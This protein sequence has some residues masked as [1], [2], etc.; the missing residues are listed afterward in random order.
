MQGVDN[1]DQSLVLNQSVQVVVLVSGEML[2]EVEEP[3]EVPAGRNLTIVGNSSENS[4]ARVKVKVSEELKVDGK[5]QLERLELSRASIGNVDVP[6]V[7]LLD[8]GTAEIIETEFRVN[9]G[10]VAIAINNGSLVLR[11]VSIAGE[12]SVMAVTLKLVTSGDVGEF[13][14]A[15]RAGL[16]QAI[17]SLAGV[18]PA[19]VALTLEAASFELTFHICISG[20]AAAAAIDA[21]VNKLLPNALEASAKLGV[22]AETA[23]DISTVDG[24]SH[25]LLGR[26]ALQPP[27]PPPL[28]PPSAM[29]VSSRS[30]ERRRL[31]ESSSEP[32][33]QCP[34]LSPSDR[35][36]CFMKRQGISTCA[37]IALG[38]TAY[39]NGFRHEIDEGKS[40]DEDEHCQQTC[41][42]TIDKCCRPPPPPPPAPSPCVMCGDRAIKSIKRAAGDKNAECADW[43]SVRGVELLL[44]KS[45]SKEF[46]ITDGI[47]Q[48]SCFD[49]SCGY[50]N[51]CP[52]P[53]SPPSPPS[54][55]PSSPMAPPAIVEA[56]IA[57][58]LNVQIVGAHNGYAI[59]SPNTSCIVGGIKTVVEGICIPSRRRLAS[60]RASLG[61]TGPSPPAGSVT[62][63][64]LGFTAASPAP[65]AP[66]APAPAPTAT[67]VVFNASAGEILNLSAIPENVTEVRLFG[68]GEKPFETVDGSW[69][70][71]AGRTLGITAIG[72]ARVKINVTGELAKVS[73]T[74]R[75]SG[76]DIFREPFDDGCGGCKVG[77]PPLL[78]ILEG[79]TVEIVES[80]LRV[81]VGELVVAVKGSLVLREAIIA[82]AS[83]DK[84][85]E[86]ASDTLPV[87]AMELL[88]SAGAWFI[89][90]VAHGMRHHHCSLPEVFFE[91][92]CQ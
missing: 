88:G 22:S 5:I 7:E 76:L 20:S 48:Q 72:D 36:T 81:V 42:V 82:G 4:E 71:P 67:Y 75:L 57:D 25:C 11:D 1:L 61:D 60:T 49:S 52:V 34:N 92:R 21:R 3:L 12:L 84:I 44:E 38:I 79:G 85:N 63:R 39:C 30:S 17:A 66:P 74:L 35:P 90:G 9:V 68:G 70:L 37:E 26:I 87:T 50:T 51:C 8:G 10:E 2:F 56:E 89:T 62:R 53:G 27:P 83:F 41:S 24:D 64:G 43:Q 45:C 73:G 58:V 28:T 59:I 91:D 16:V 15:D 86:F 80:E 54:A 46:W 69:E 29:A 31:T 47:C 14:A 65:S 32:C 55:P 78:D 6:L 13:T 23:P 19:A 77:F 40:F 33:E 18:P